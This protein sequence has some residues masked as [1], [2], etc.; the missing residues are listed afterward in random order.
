MR[1]NKKRRYRINKRGC[2]VRILIVLAVLAV[3][4]KGINLLQEQ[5]VPTPGEL[6]EMG[7]PES[8][9]ELY[10]K[11]EEARDFVLEYDKTKGVSDVINLNDKVVPG[12]IPHFLQWDER[13]GYG[14]YGDDFMAVVGCGPT[15]LSMVYCGL[16]GDYSLNPWEVAKMG[17]SRGYYV[18]GAG[19]S[20]NMMD[21][22]AEDIG[23]TVLPVYFDKE[24]ILEELR[25]GHPIICIMGPGDFT[26]EGHFIV[27]TD[28]DKK[29]KVTVN[30]PNSKKKSD[31]KWD[32]ELIMEQA[33]NLWGYEY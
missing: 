31:K 11:N 23:L 13:W 32:V 3:V 27:L 14:M 16:T 12:G 9:V 28:A 7:Y 6:K 5:N 25:A 10:E 29:G 4:I 21:E 8:L 18:S 1:G 24:Y 30:D 33:R 2:L 17:E 22:M 15:S 20:W 19:T 26:T